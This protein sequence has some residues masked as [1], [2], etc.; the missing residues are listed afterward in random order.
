[1]YRATARGCFVIAEDMFVV[2][3][4]PEGLILSATITVSGSLFGLVSERDKIRG[5]GSGSDQQVGWSFHSP[6]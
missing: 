3:L 5:F 4:L 2:A 6:A 1:M